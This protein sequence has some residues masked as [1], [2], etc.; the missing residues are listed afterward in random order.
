MQLIDTHCHLDD[1][2]LDPDRDDVIE[3]ARLTGVEQIIVPAVKRSGW[4]KLADLT[5]QCP[6]VVPAY[7][8]HPW[9]CD[10]HVQDDIDLLSTYL[11]AAKAV[12]EC[13][14]DFGKGRASE[15]EQ[16][17][18]FRAQLELAHALKLPVILHAYKSLDTVLCELRAFP[19]LRGVIH[20]FS[21]SQQQAEAAINQG[22]YLGIGGRIT[23]PQSGRLQAIVKD[24]PLQ[25]LLIETDAP[26]QSGVNH[27]GQRNEPAF[28]IEIANEIATMRDLEATELAAICNHNARELFAI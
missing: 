14:L 15:A 1:V 3:R 8:L 4:Q 18:W 28:L 2:L 24:M 16:L 25:H 13:G 7:G 17:K 9:Y 11:G 20:G 21:G 22:L 12:G 26:D 23:F 19:D 10:E 5:F 6:M 27:Q